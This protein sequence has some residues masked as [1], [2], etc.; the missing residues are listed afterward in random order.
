MSV[1]G[2]VTKRFKHKKP[3]NMRIRFNKYLQMRYRWNCLV[4]H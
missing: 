1:H 2:I 4:V 3:P